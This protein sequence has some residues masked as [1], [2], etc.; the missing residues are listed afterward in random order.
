[1]RTTDARH[2]AGLLESGWKVVVRAERLEMTGPDG[3]HLLVRPIDRESRDLCSLFETWVRGDYGLTF[4]GMNVLDVG[5]GNGDSAI[6]FAAR[7]A[8]KVVTVEPDPRSL[9]MLRENLALNPTLRQISLIEAGVTADG[10]P[11]ELPLSTPYAT[12]SRGAPLAAPPETVKVPGLAVARL[13]EMVPKVDLL[14]VD[15]EGGEYAVLR[16]IPSDGWTR[17][18]AVRLEFHRGLQELPELFESHGF[19]VTASMGVS[20]GLLFA[21]RVT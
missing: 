14:K 12:V 11:L 6:C 17:I 3:T 16:A 2:L 4:R 18:G 7:G 9:E 5:G 13:L 10:S 21:L 15:I 19:E 1:V 20:Q 8:A